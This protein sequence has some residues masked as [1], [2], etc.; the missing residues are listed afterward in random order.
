MN[1][2]NKLANIHPLLNKFRLR[3]KYYMRI[4]FM[5]KKNIIQKKNRYISLLELLSGYQF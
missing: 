2:E 4:P 3:D 1:P 5:F